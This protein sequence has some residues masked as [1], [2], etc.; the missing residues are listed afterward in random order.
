MELRIRDKCGQIA[1]CRMILTQEVEGAQSCRKSYDLC[2]ACYDG[3]VVS[4]NKTKSPMPR[5][6]TQ[7]ERVE[8][9]LENLGMSAARFAKECDFTEASVSRWRSGVCKI[10]Q[11][12]ARK[13]ED[14]YPQFSIPWIMGITNHYKEGQ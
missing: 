3:V 9:M 2:R 11:S 8:F 12:S 5:M 7:P 13:I 14:R 10:G 6:M 1:D 4:M